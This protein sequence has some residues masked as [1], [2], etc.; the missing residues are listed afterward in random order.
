MATVKRLRASAICEAEG[1]LL[2][3]RLRDPVSGVEAPYPPGGGVEPGELPAETARR[4]TL[5][6]TGLRVR[7]DPMLK[8]VDSYPFLW[9]GVD[10]E[11]TTHYFGAALEGA[12]DATI[13]PVIDADYN[14]GAAWMPVGEALDAMAVHPAIA[15]S[16]S[17][18]IRLARRS[19]WLKH[20]NVVG[21][22]GTLL[23]IHDQFRIASDRLSLV[24][25]RESETGTD[26][27]YVARVFRPLA[28]TLHHHHHAEEAMLFTLIEH[29]TGTA[30]ERLVTD[31][32]ELTRAIAEVEASLTSDADRARANAAVAAFGEVLG[33]HL[34]REEALV[35]PVL[36]RM[37]P[38][39]AWA[40]IHG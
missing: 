38:D 16:V 5:E 29:R 24:L 36:L 2:V 20:P 18:V 37:T 35:I 13:A 11:V 1:R 30:P 15:S 22:A 7:V 8:V 31:H 40:L 14:L 21:P 34:D 26:L 9:A 32:E 25:A 12:F 4:E 10:Y 28:Q 33:A 19:A 6:E 23:G 3:V 27:G 39:E 17:K